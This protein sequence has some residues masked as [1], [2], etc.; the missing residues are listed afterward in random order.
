MFTDVSTFSSIEA[1]ISKLHQLGSSVISNVQLVVQRIQECHGHGTTP[2]DDE[3]VITLVGTVMDEIKLFKNTLEEVRQLHAKWVSQSAAVGPKS[4]SEALKELTE[5]IFKE[6]SQTEQRIDATK[7]LIV[8]LQMLKCANLEGFIQVSKRMALTAKAP[9]DWTPGAPLP[10]NSHRL[11]YPTEDLIR[12]SLLFQ[13]TP[14]N[15]ESQDAGA[16]PGN[17]QE[18]SDHREDP[19]AQLLLDLD[20]NPDML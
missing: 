10:P 17:F 12:S 20:L 5:V 11:P 6:L 16:E 9:K 1:T 13:S 4:G 3:S 15:M 19:E 8:K 2:T 18:E 14:D 7:N